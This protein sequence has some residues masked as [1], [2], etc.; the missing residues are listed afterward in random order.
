[1]LGIVAGAALARSNK[2]HLSYDQESWFPL[3]NQDEHVIGA[4][5]ATV[6][7][8]DP[9]GRPDDRVFQG[10]STVLVTADRPAGVCPKGAGRIG[11]LHS[12]TGP[13]V[14]WQIPL[15]SLDPPVEAS[16]SSG[17]YVSMSRTGDSTPWILIAKPRVVRDGRFQPVDVSELARSIPPP[18]IPARLP[19][20]QAPP[21]GTRRRADPE[22]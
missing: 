1:M 8:M 12:T 15:D 2:L 3:P 5:V 6:L 4:Y 11:P 20:L 9:M 19:H 16:S 21:R 14:A 18:P 7:L 22:G 10:S 17:R 13:V